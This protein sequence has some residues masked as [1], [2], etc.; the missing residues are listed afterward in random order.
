MISDLKLKNFKKKK[1]QQNI[2]ND[3]NLTAL[4]D[5]DIFSM[6]KRNIKTRKLT[7]GQSFKMLFP[8]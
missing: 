7:Q 5:A 8:L 6:I 4:S 2:I 3:V 1:Q